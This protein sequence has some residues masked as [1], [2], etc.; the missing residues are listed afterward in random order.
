MN[1]MLQLLEMLNEEIDRLD[2][3]ISKPERIDWDTFAQIARDFFCSDEIKKAVE[4]S[5]IANPIFS[6]QIEVAFEFRGVLL[7][8]ISARQF[9]GLGERFRKIRRL[10]SA[11]LKNPILEWESV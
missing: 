6:E 2:K 5:H 4:S 1:Q 11:L 9:V 7:S 10:Y 8:E 3:F